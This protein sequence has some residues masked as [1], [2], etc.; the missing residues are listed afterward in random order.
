MPS[1]DYKEI[2]LILL[3]I[4]FAYI[5]EPQARETGLCVNLTLGMVQDFSVTISDY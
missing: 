3:A 5:W 4:I 2:P 1:S